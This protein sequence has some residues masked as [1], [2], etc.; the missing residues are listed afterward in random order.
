[1]ETTVETKSK[2]EQMLDTIGLIVD[3]LIP[4][5]ITHQSTEDEKFDGRSAS[6]RGAQGQAL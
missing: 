1:M 3:K 4:L 6:R 2:H 5:G